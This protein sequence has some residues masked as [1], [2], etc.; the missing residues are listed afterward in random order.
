MSVGAVGLP[1][2]MTPRTSP[3]LF[4]PQQRTDP[5]RRTA[6]VEEKPVAICT[7]S[8]TPATAAGVVVA[9]GRF[10]SFQHQTSPPER[11]AQVAPPP[12]A[13]AVAADGNGTVTG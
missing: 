4:K 8:E 5:S 13:I 2:G 1:S 7:T 9:P 10:V 12:A 11:T 3:P 6:H